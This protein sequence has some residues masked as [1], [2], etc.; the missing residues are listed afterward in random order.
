MQ[1]CL[2]LLAKGLDWGLGTER[3]V[4]AHYFSLALRLVGQNRLSNFFSKTE[5]IIIT[6]AT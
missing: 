5:A 6:Y 4:P 3:P 2:S 1:A